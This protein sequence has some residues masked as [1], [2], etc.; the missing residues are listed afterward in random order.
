MQRQVEAEWLDELAADD[1][2]ALG[3]RRDLRLID[4]FMGNSRWI[5]RRCR[6]DPVSIRRIVEGGAG[7]GRLAQRFLRNYPEVKYRAVDTG[8]FPSRLPEGAEWHQADLRE[9]GA[10][11][12]AE[13][14]LGSLI[15]HQFEEEDL[16]KLGANVIDS[17]IQRM[18]VAEPRRARLHVWQLRA[19][20]LIGFNRVSLHDGA[21][22]IRGGFRGEELPRMLGLGKENWDWRISET[23]RGAYRMEAW[24]R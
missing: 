17:G 11:G 9:S 5:L 8:P 7:E 18:L 1:P 24:R 21:V 23:L 13:L 14:F 10:L 6:R 3:N 2:L 19:G 12:E 16:G 20:V 15:L 4:F 22:S